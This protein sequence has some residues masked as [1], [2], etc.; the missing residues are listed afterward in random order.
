[1]AKWTKVGTLRKTKAGGQAIKIAEDVNLKKDMYLQVQDP[2]KKLE[3]SVEA[4]RL[5][6]DKASELA[7]K[8][9]DYILG[10]IYLVQE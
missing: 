1:M 2:L 3:E 8:I 7:A 9:P 4:G 6:E 10:E 5:S